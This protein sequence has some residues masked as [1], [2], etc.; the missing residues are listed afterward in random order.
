M[1]LNRKERR[2]QERSAK[3]QEKRS[4]RRHHTSMGSHFIRTITV[5]Q[6]KEFK[7]SRLYI[8]MRGDLLT[9]GTCR[10]TYDHLVTFFSEEVPTKIGL[11]LFTKDKVL[12]AEEL[13]MLFGNAR[14]QVPKVLLSH[15][16]YETLMREIAY[17]GASFTRTFRNVLTMTALVNGTPYEFLRGLQLRPVVDIKSVQ[18]DSGTLTVFEDSP[19]VVNI[20]E[21]IARGLSAEDAVT[22]AMNARSRDS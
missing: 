4:Q 9:E 7:D 13:G 19:L 11:Q 8:D 12:V 18:M 22:E 1:K 21:A 2:K 14:G 20:K 3:K 6:Q 5:Q 17:S 10:D 16:A 15:T